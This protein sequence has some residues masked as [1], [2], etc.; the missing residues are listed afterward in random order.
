MLPFLSLCSLCHYNISPFFPHVGKVSLSSIIQTALTP[1]HLRRQECAEMFREASLGVSV[2]RELGCVFCVLR[3]VKE[4]K[5]P[6]N[7]SS[8]NSTAF[9][10]GVYSFTL[11]F[12]L[13]LHLNTTLSLFHFV[14]FSSSLQ[15][16]KIGKRKCCNSSW[17]LCEAF[18]EPVG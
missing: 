18:M 11:Y 13:S 14:R 16:V 3:G 1:S 4:K 8:N 5:K 6:G 10:H 12:Q 17:V 9:Q 2:Q 15:E 7:G